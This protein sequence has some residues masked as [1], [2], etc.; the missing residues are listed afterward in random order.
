MIRLIR[1]LLVMISLALC[2]G[3]ANG[4][5]GA[6]PASS[7]T[8]LQDPLVPGDAIRLTFW[9]ESAFNGEYPVDE[10]GAVMLPL[11]GERRVTDLSPVILREELLRDYAEQQRNKEVQISLLRRVRIIGEVNSPG[12]YL[13]DPTMTLADAVAQAGGPTPDGRL[14]AIHILR[15]NEW[16]VSDSRGGA[17]EDTWP[18]SRDQIVVPKRSWLSRNGQ[19]VAGALISTVGIIVAIRY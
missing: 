13:V 10:T 15:G 1:W 9:R 14:D 8:S 7:E 16:I 18:H 11:V 6:V 4:E 5:A 12:L 2:A 17:T 19:F 3:M